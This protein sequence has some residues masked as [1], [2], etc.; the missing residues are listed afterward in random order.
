M[1][2]LTFTIHPGVDVDDRQWLEEELEEVLGPGAHCTG[3]G[4]SLDG[5]GSDFQIE[6]ASGK[7]APE[8]VEACWRRLEQLEITRDI[9]LDLRTEDGREQRFTWSPAARRP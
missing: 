5:S 9:T 2:T 8:I 6:L 3:G 4:G 7:P 1:L